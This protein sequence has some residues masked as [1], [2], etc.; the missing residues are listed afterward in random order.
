MSSSCEKILLLKCLQ[1][2]FKCWPYLYVVPGMILSGVI[3]I[4]YAI[5]TTSGIFSV[6][7][8]VSIISSEVVNMCEFEA[9]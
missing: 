1:V 7:A 3:H 2:A 8:L 4:Y 9:L 6:I 5:K